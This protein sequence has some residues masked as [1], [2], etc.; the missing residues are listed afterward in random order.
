M[1]LLRAIIL[2][3]SLCSSLQPSLHS[4]PWRAIVP[5]RKVVGYSRTYRAGFLFAAFAG[6]MKS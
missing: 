1:L 4:V 6:V 5:D 2:G 3:P